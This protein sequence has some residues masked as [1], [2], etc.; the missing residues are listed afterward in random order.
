MWVTARLTPT[1]PIPGGWRMATAASLVLAGV[2]FTAAGVRAFRRAGTTINPVTPQAASAFVTQG[3]FGRTRNPMYV[4]FTAVLLGWSAWLAA[5]W[6]LL[7]PLAFAVFL[8]RFQIIPEERVL[9][10]KFGRSFDEY[11]Q[12]VRRWL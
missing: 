11:R 4:G 9:R 2:T 8:T 6:A 7:G 12:R 10:A 1:V 3:A 5:P